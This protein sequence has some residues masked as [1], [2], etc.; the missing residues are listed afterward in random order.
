MVL[1]AGG[2]GGEDE[3]ATTA[4]TDEGLSQEQYTAAV[5]EAIGPVA[6]ESQQLI[7]RAEEASE[8]EDM[9]HPLGDAQLVYQDATDQL[10]SLDPPSDVDDLHGELVRAQREIA[11]AARAAK[12]AAR[13]DDREGLEEFRAAGDRYR[14]SAEE[15]SKEYSERGFEF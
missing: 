8:V 13:Q 9:A 7:S 5:R 10:E 1:V 11:D 2:C 6:A 4:S 3:A 14:K 15:L 12:L